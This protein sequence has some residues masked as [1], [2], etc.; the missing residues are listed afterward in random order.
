ML[1][2]QKVKKIHS[3]PGVFELR[4]VGGIQVRLLFMLY[5]EKIFLITHCFVKKTQKTPQKELRL[6][7]KRAKEFI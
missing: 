1:E 5:D 6:A 3:K 2:S 7:I 4:I